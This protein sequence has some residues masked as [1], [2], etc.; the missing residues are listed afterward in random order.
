ML[1]AF[2]PFLIQLSFRCGCA[3][4]LCLVAEVIRHAEGGDK[5]CRCE[6]TARSVA[7]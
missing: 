3:S 2:P 7:P 5:R 1:L 4:R 6:D